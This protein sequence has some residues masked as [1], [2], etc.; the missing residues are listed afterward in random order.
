MNLLWAAAVFLV[1]MLL[2]LIG[3]PTG[4]AGPKDAAYVGV[5]GG[6]ALGFAVLTALRVRAPRTTLVIAAFGVCAYYIAGLPSIGVV[7]PLLVFLAAA[8]A[9]GYR[10]F[11]LATALVLF[12]V[13]SY[14]RI[15]GGESAETVLGY[16]LLSN[17]AMALLAVAL[18]EIV[19]TRRKL[20]ENQQKL[21]D[22]AA[23]AARSEADRRQLAERTR[24][25]RQLHDELGHYLAVVS[26]H[27]NAAMETVLADEAATASLGHVRDASAKALAALRRTVDSL[28]RG[29]PAQRTAGT[30]GDVIELASTLR[31]A[32]LRVD[33]NA[34]GLD[35]DQRLPA[36]LIRLV[37]EAATNAVKHADTT[38]LAIFLRAQPPEDE[39]TQW[40]VS[41][42]NDGLRPGAQETAD[43]T[44]LASLRQKVIDTGGSMEWGRL[45]RHFLLSA[46]IWQALGK[47]P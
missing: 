7:L 27:T 38:H 41:V 9:A 31:D 6:F 37:Q 18:A 34:P 8:T 4:W 20:Q 17:V 25:S 16:E 44:G 23:E 13:A 12:V 29:E 40:H 46:E 47:A 5:A 35:L 21:I 42:R 1:V 15:M 32:G 30:L 3:E 24:I 2:A 14:Y 26:L 36:L 45:G 39:R 10:T 43:G 11:A 19:T 22:L 28:G 33:V